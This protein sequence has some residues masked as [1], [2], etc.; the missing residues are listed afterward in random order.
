MNTY[1][2]SN[3][4]NPEQ[5]SPYGIQCAVNSCLF[6]VVRSIKSG[7]CKSASGCAQHLGVIILTKLQT[8]MTLLL[9]CILPNPFDDVKLSRLNEDTV[10]DAVLLQ[11]FFT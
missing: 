4:V 8:G 6:V 9:Q 3:S 5:P 11:I 2:G 10:D 7:C 1:A